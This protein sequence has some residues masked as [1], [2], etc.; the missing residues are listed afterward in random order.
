VKGAP[1]IL[2][3]AKQRGLVASVRPFLEQMRATGYF[4]A[5]AVIERALREAGD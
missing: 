5:P 3:A 2:I 4:L 1:G